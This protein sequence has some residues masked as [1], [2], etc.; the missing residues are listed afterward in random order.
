M[1]SVISG[2]MA[3]LEIQDRRDSLSALRQGKRARAESAREIWE[4]AQT[5][6]PEQERMSAHVAAVLLRSIYGRGCVT[7][8]MVERRMKSWDER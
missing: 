1:S 6:F 8:A 7:R 3:G 2:R 4:W 5:H